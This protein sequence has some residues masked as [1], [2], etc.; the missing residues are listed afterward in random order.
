MSIPAATTM[1]KST[2]PNKTARKSHVGTSIR[3]AMVDSSRNRRRRLRLPPMVA[4]NYKSVPRTLTLMQNLGTHMD[5]D[6]LPPGLY[7]TLV[8]SGIE[9]ALAQLG[10]LAIVAAIVEAESPLRLSDHLRRIAERVLS[11]SDYA[12]NLPAQAQLVNRV[13]ELLRTELGVADDDVVDPPRF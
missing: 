10:D 1:A 7:E 11:E 12:G 4:D 3:V 2:P 8:T 9:S 6:S 13:I 5:P